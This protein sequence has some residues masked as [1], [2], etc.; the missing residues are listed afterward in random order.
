MWRMQTPVLIISLSCENRQTH[1]VRQQV[2]Q[3]LPLW[4]Q[5]QGSGFSC[6]V[7][8]ELPSNPEQSP[9]LWSS[10]CVFASASAA[11]LS[12]FW[13]VKT[14]GMC[15]N[16]VEGATAKDGWGKA[17]KTRNLPLS[18]I[19]VVAPNCIPWV[20]PSSSSSSFLPN[21]VFCCFVYPCL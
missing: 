1:G 11:S 6:P 12:P 7:S 8:G 20:P 21:L 17:E 2:L 9:G 4:T 14:S 10:G 18:C 15:L 5:S 16:E 19:D 13:S 3:S